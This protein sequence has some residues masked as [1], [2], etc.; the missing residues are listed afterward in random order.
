MFCTCSPASSSSAMP[1][2]AQPPPPFGAAPGLAAF[3]WAVP[4][5]VWLS[6]SFGDSGLTDE[7]PFCSQ[8]TS[9]GQGFA[10]CTLGLLLRKTSCRWLSCAPTSMR[11]S[12]STPLV[13]ALER[14]RTP[15]LPLAHCE[16]LS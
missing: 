10:T 6:V 16:P 5:A 7:D 4:L 9:Q 8:D 2:F 13:G 12:P 3:L 15:P 14:Q 1:W 11:R